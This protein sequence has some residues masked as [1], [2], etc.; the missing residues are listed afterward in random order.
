[1]EAS[2]GDVGNL[3]VGIAD[4]I[5]NVANEEK[6]GEFITL[7]TEHGAIGGVTLQGIAF[8]ASVN[9]KAV[10]DSASQFDFYD[11]GGLDICYVSFAEVDQMGN[12]NVHRFNGKIMGTGGF[13]NISQNSRKIVFCGTLKSG[14]LRTKVGEGKIEILQEGRFVKLLPEVEEITFHAKEA[15]KSGKEV[16]YVTER[17]VFRMTETGIELCE[18]APGLDMERDVI[19]HMGFRPQIAKQVKT[20]DAR[21]FESQPMNLKQDWVKKYGE[22][23]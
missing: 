22:L 20:M 19:K 10:I 11:G 13:V 1:M 12:V 17:A 14:G 3:G 16:W 5:G 8:G 2:P 15:V 7:T 4:G 23:D 18:I 9:M 6:V 21:L